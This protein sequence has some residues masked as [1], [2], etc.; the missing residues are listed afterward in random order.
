MRTLLQLHQGIPGIL[1]ARRQ[2]QRILRL[3]NHLVLALAVRII[4]SELL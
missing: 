1:E 2:I 3:N 4:Y